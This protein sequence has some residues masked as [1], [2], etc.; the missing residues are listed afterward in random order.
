MM[1]AVP[2][3]GENAMPIKLLLADDQEVVRAGV[4]ALLAGTDIKVVAEAATADAVLKS[5]KSQRWVTVKQA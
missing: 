4:K 3:W 2:L 1:M 5:A